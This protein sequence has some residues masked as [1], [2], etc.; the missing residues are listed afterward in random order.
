MFRDIFFRHPHVR[1][2]TGNEEGDDLSAQLVPKALDEMTEP[3]KE[4][5]L[6]ESKKFAA[7]LEQCMFDGYA[8]HDKAGNLTPGS[9]Y[10]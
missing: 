2:D 7:E 8:E 9:S 10:K 4:A 1:N 3:E 6:E 5:L